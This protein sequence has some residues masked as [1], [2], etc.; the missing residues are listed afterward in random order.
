MSEERV[1]DIVLKWGNAAKQG[2]K[3]LKIELYKAEQWKHSW[4]PFKRNMHPHPPLHDQGEYWQQYYRMR[5]GGKWWRM[6]KYKYAFY[7]LDQ[8]ITLTDSLYKACN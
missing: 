5:V 7:T 2:K 4:N 3:P 8:A 6:P 1:A